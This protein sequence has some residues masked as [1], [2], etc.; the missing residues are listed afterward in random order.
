[1]QRKNSFIFNIQAVVSLIGIALSI[2]A[3][4]EYVTLNAGY[5]SKN[6]FCNISETFSCERVILSTYSDWFGI[7]V[8]SY[9]LFFYLC[10]FCIALASRKGDLIPHKYSAGV[11]LLL[12][13]LGILVSLF[14]FLL[15]K[16][17]IGAFC[18]VCF[19][20][21]LVN[22]IL[23]ACAFFLNK[24]YSAI[25]ALSA[26]LSA[27]FHFIGVVG[28]IRNAPQMPRAIYQLG[29]ILLLSLAL[30]SYGAEDFLWSRFLYQE[31]A[32]SSFVRKWQSNQK[33]QIDLELNTGALGDYLK[34]QPHAPIQV[35][36]FFDFECPH[37]RSFYKEMS[38]LMKEYAGKVSLV[39]KNYPL[40]KTCNTYMTKEFHGASCFAAEFAR[41]SGEQGKYWEATDFLLTSSIMEENLS[42]EEIKAKILEKS[43]VLNLDNQA[44]T[45]CIKSGRQ[46]SKIKKDIEQAQQLG[47]LGT[48]TLWINGKRVETLNVD[49]WKAI[50]D[51]ILKHKS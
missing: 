28:Y 44:I 50:F 23:F 20:M 30:V 39:M 18:P 47:V 41:C 37:C 9:G 48:P 32:K 26:G 1:M 8:A 17:V 51:S 19:S 10:F 16:L 2:Y 43:A 7:P 11:S 34:G 24:G 38:N 29:L 40:D 12:S 21:Y 35:L 42:A 45:E 13:L 22:I 3:L 36:E 27:S 15:S 6:F 46:S 4:Y 25:E 14:L 49:T 33:T 5:N 31:L